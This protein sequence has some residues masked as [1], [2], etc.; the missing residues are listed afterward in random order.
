MSQQIQGNYMTANSYDLPGASTSGSPS[1]SDDLHVYRFDKITLPQRERMY[2]PMFELKLSYTDVYHC[3]VSTDD[4][5]AS[6]RSS[7]S[8]HSQ[9]QG[10][11][12]ASRYQDVWHAIRIPNNTKL[13]WTTAPVM[14]NRGN[15]FIGQDISSYT[16]VG[17][18]SLINITKSLNVKVLFDESST[19]KQGEVTIISS[20]YRVY[21]NVGKIMVQ[22][23]KAEQVTVMLKRIIFGELGQTSVKPSSNIESPRTDVANATRT[24]VWEVN[25]PAGGS[26]QIQYES[27]CNRR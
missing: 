12:A 7:Y 27:T 11:S 17:D 19:A 2:L 4:P 25:V 10:S 24:V 3:T 1:D 26:V 8:S 9:Q 18:K 14:V 6:S 15:Q 13:P 21:T 5:S 20:I 16:N 23:Q 22:N